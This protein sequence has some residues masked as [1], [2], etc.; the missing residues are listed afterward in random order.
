MRLS[1]SLLKIVFCVCVTALCKSAI[2]DLDDDSFQTALDSSNS[3]W[4]LYFYA[5]WCGHCKKVGPI[6]E[7]VAATFSTNL[8]LGKIDATVAKQIALEHDINTFPTIKY[9]KQGKYGLYNGDRNYNDIVAFVNRVHDISVEKIDSES[10]LEAHLHQTGLLFL[11]TVDT[12]STAGS[13]VLK[14]FTAVAEHLKLQ[15]NFAYIHRTGSQPTIEKLEAHRK[16]L[17]IPLDVESSVID[18]ND[19]IALIEHHNHL[20]VNPIDKSNFRRLG[21][22]G[23]PLII[24]VVDYAKELETEEVIYKLDAAASEV[25]NEQ[26]H[27]HIFGHMDGR[28]WAHYLTQKFTKAKPPYILVFDLSVNGYYVEKNCSTEAI[29]KV[30]QGAVSKELD[31][32]VVESPDMTFTDRVVK[33]FNRYYPWSLILCIS[34][35]VMLL[36]SYLFPHPGSKKRKHA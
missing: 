4:L 34:P 23:K 25:P 6:L 2:V 36:L 26:A 3:L 32:S 31:F 18:E 20:L 35:G 22:T 30:V 12:E 11:L 16:A 7:D 14:T 9:F 21:R 33:K 15:A 5:P 24:A 17:L 1:V 8:T 29:E 13:T 27:Q 10:E 19:M 28:R